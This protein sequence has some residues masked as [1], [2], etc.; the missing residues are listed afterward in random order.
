MTAGSIRPHLA[1]IETASLG[2]MGGTLQVTSVG[3]N[4]PGHN[5]Q[6]QFH[7]QWRVRS[8]EMTGER[9]ISAPRQKVWEA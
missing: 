4:P 8:M 3:H 6:A 1:V 2:C 7:A 5:T 9:H